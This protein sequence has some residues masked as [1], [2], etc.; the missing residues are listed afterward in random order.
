MQTVPGMEADK[1]WTTYRTVCRGE[2]GCQF[3]WQ[4]VDDDK[5]EAESPWGRR[6]QRVI[7]IFEGK[8]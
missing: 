7:Q 4:K 6:E 8:K 5:G 3:S 2:K 1:H